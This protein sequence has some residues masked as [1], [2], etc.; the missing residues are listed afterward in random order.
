M[1]LIQQTY[2][3]YFFSARKLNYFTLGKPCWFVDQVVRFISNI[4]KGLQLERVEDI[5]Y[6]CCPHIVLVLAV[7]L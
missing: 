6:S 1:N 3:L 4:F 7:P 2:A 5:H